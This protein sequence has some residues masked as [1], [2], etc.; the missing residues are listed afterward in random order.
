M[1]KYVLFLSWWQPTNCWSRRSSPIA[2]WLRQW[3]KGM[4]KSAP[5]RIVSLCLKTMSGTRTDPTFPEGKHVSLQ[6]GTFFWRLLGLLSCL[7][8]SFSVSSLC[9]I[10][11]LII[12]S[13]W[14]KAIPPRPWVFLLYHHLPLSSSGPTLNSFCLCQTCMFA[15]VCLCPIRSVFHICTDWRWSKPLLPPTVF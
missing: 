15:W 13:S 12:Y 3:D 1:H 6:E 10:L 7:P 4:H 11:Y 5:W 9:Y 2:T 14:Q 8:N